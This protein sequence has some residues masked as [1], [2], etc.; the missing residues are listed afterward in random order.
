MKTGELHLISTGNQRAEEL[1]DILS[2][3]HPYI[4]FIHLRE[5]ARSAKD[6]YQLIQLL[7]DKK[8]PRSK[9][10]MND[11]I[12]VAMAANINSIQLASNSLP[13]ELVKKTFPHVKAGCSI[14]SAEE[15]R[16]AEKNGADFLFFGHIYPTQS[17]P[18]LSPRGIE[19]LRIIVESVD[20]PVIAIGGITPDLTPEVVKAGAKGIA[21]MSGVLEDADP[22]K[23]VQSYRTSLTK[24]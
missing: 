1:A 24:E 21:V 8:V 20:I 16:L 22:L 10:V 19:H 18:G 9:I 5:K 7:I 13:V 2:Q 15:A 6:I 12:D 11:R 23:T 4:D 3:I 14:H 17:K